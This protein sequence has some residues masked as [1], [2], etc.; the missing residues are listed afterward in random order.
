MSALLKETLQTWKTSRLGSK[1]M[2]LYALLDG[3]YVPARERLESEL[4]VVCEILQR[5]PFDEKKKTYNSMRE[6][7]TTAAEI[8]D[9]EQ[10]AFY[11]D[12]MKCW[13][14]RVE[15]LPHYP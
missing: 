4:E 13:E 8:E 7:K 3:P 15:Q 11:R 1:F 9:Y 5:R 2:T 12:M 10:A 6:R 14:S